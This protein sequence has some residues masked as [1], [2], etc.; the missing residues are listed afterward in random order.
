MVS[1][2]YVKF[3]Q[4]ICDTLR[5][6]SKSAYDRQRYLKIFKT[7][8]NQ[9]YLLNVENPRDNLIEIWKQ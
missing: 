3:D 7:N 8:I 2:S 6:K 1:C 4:V 9:T 5:H